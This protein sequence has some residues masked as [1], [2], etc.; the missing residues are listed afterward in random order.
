MDVKENINLQKEITHHPWESARAEIVWQQLRQ[1]LHNSAAE[2]FFILDYG[3]G[4]LYQSLSLAKRDKRIKIFAL[5]LAYTEDFRLQLNTLIEGQNISMV[6]SVSDLPDGIVFSAVL[7]M[8]VIEHI[9]ND[10]AF[11]DDL[12]SMR[13]FGE[14]TEYYITVP[15]WQYLFSGHDEYLGHYR[16]YTRRTLTAVCQNAGLTPLQS[17]YLFI[18]L[19]KLRIIQRIYRKIF[20]SR[21]EV[22]SDLAPWTGPRWL[23]RLLS[24]ILVGDYYLCRWFSK[25]GLHLPGLSAYALCKRKP[26]LFGQL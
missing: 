23:A 14:N 12:A 13:C 6:H 22:K 7:L 3:S 11:L 9:N 21:P 8:D 4:D 16:R 25:I 18:S 26:G 5:D 19:W 24:F 1:R 20:K 15:A 17:G 10:L 2:H